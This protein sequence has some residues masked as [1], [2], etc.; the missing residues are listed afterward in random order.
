MEDM[1]RFGLALVSVPVAVII[2]GVVI[3]LIGRW[4]AGRRGG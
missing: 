1:A 3:G 2:G 4:I